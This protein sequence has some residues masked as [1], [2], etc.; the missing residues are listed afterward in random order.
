MQN[1][2]LKYF[3]RLAFCTI[4]AAV[5]FNIC[6]CKNDKVDSN[7]PG[8]MD[9][10]QVG[11]KSLLPENSRPNKEVYTWTGK[12]DPSLFKTGRFIYGNSIQFGG[13]EIIRGKDSQLDSGGYDHLAFMFD[14]KWD[15]DTAYTLKYK[16]TVANPRSISLPDLKG[17]YRKCFMTQLTD[18]SY[19]EIST[20]SMTKDTIYTTVIKR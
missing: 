4:A 18:T 16:K 9:T 19:M 5:L 10:T 1:S 12:K 20:S 13:F 14:L 11:R 6:S 3:T 7:E 15:N 8:T 17:M 2:Q